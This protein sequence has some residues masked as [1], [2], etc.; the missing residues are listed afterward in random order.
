MLFYRNWAGLHQL[1]LYEV[2]EI[3]GAEEYEPNEPINQFSSS[4]LE[5]SRPN[6]LDQGHSNHL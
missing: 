5:I 6:L 2:R 1:L 3:K 4:H